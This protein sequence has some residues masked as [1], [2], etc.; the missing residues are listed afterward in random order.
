MYYEE[1]GVPM[2][3]SALGHLAT[4]LGKYELECVLVDDGSKDRTSEEARRCFAGMPNTI[5]AK[6]EVNLGPGA[7]FRTGFALA[8][9]DLVCTMDADCTF[10]PLKFPAMIRKMQEEG[11][12]VITASPYHPDGGVENVPAWR[13]LLSRGASFLYRRISPCKLYTYTSF[14]R[15]H[16]REVVKK[17]SFRNNGF[18]GFAE[19]LLHAALQGYK[20]AEFPMVL[21][22]R[23]VG[24]SKMKVMYTIRTHLVLMKQAMAWR[25]SGKSAQQALAARQGH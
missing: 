7:A 11:A 5:F 1:A 25:L 24:A 18:A 22:S 17:V 10:D 14:M 20:I 4:A 23:A 3:A 13:L 2:L 12:D 6:H 16:R 8:T 15:V 9:G 19:M 21:C